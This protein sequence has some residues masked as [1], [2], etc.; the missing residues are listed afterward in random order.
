MENNL[1]ADHYAHSMSKFCPGVRAYYIPGVKCMLKA[2]TFPQAGYANGSQGRMIGLVHEDPNYVLPSGFPGEMIMIPPPR[3]IIMEVHH[4][5]KEKRTSILPCEMEATEIEYYRDSKKFIYRCWSNMV[6][7]TFALTVHETQGQTLRRIILLLGRLPGMN[8]GRITWSLLYVALSRTKKLRHVKLFPT[9]STKYYHPMYFSH[10]LKLS[11]PVNLRRWHRSYVDHTWDRNILRDEHAQSVRKVERKLKQLGEDKTR[12]L[13]WVEL[14]SLVKQ[15]RYKATTRDNKSILFCKLK[16]HMIKRLIWKT[17]INSKP[18]K[19]KRSRAR[20]RK[21][22]AVEVDSCV[23][24]KSSLRRSKIMR[25]STAS[26]KMHD[27][28]RTS[29]RN[30]SSRMRFV[31]QELPTFITKGLWNLGN[32]CYFNSVV[33]CLYHCPTFKRAIE[34]VPSEVLLV[35]V[36]N[37]L[38]ILFG[39][40]TAGGPFSYIT[41]TEC[42]TAA[43]NIPEC[44]SAGM[45]VNGPQQDAGE[46]LVHLLTH[47]EATCRHLSDIFEG[48]LVS[49]RTCQHC[50]YSHRGNQPFKLYS[51]QMDLPVTNVIQP[52]DLY[53]LMHYFHRTENLS[54][55]HCEH[56]N[57]HNSKKKLSIIT[58]PRILVIHLSRFRGL[59][60]INKHVRFDAQVSIKHNID[61][62]EYNTQYQLTGIVVHIGPS[63]QVGHYVSYVR[64]GEM[65]FKMN[66][67]RVRTVS[68]LTVQRQK[69]YLLFF[70]QI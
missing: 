64:A 48:Q 2:N 55:S 29:T 26:K 52:I 50:F 61:N 36:V 67:D 3:F 65:W 37:Q 57:T 33:Q 46:F 10:L 30:L 11:M 4:I 15:M 18:A 21:A 34:T 56:C 16:E 70:E 7:L 45:I 66:D 35:A 58:L 51:L 41:P 69:A 1:A 42:L 22:L 39:D 13:K 28:K 59:Q 44:K 24:V 6:V 31:S 25:G 20:K 19:T 54:D 32:S 27:Q 63:I 17:S 12:G 47:F 40:M 49:I 62:N 23:K 38:Q 14:F 5:G 8:V 53:K 43:M 60:K 9:G 68:W